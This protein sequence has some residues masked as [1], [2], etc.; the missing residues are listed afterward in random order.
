MKRT[1]KVLGTIALL[2]AVIVLG[3]ACG[4][5]EPAT[6]QTFQ[7]YNV[8]GTVIASY[9]YRTSYNVQ[10]VMHVV[11][12][13]GENQTGTENRKLLFEP[14]VYKERFPSYEIKEGSKVIFVWD[15]VAEQ[16]GHSNAAADLIV[17]DGRTLIR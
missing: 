16:I 13:S 1:F 5:S 17:L 12:T 10:G 7:Q 3:S 6:R 14:S 4:S 11:D 9:P 15:A 2:A 8:D